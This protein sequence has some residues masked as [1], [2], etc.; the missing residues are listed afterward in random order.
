MTRHEFF[1]LFCRALLLVRSTLKYRRLTIANQINDGDSHAARVQG[2]L[3]ASTQVPHMTEDGVELLRR[4]YMQGVDVHK[5]IALSATI[6]ACESYKVPDCTEKR[7]E[8]AAFFCPLLFSTLGL[9]EMYELLCSLLIERSVVFVSENLNLLT[10]ASYIIW[11]N[12]NN[13]R[14]A[15]CSLIHPLK[16]QYILIPIVP[17]PLRELLDAP[18]PYIAGLNR[19]ALELRHIAEGAGSA[20]IVLLDSG[21]IVHPEEPVLPSLG[22]L[23]VAL[24]GAYKVFQRRGEAGLHYSA[25]EAETAAALEITARIESALQERVFAKLP[26][27]RSLVA[28][29]GQEVDLETVKSRVKEACDP[30]DKAFVERFAD[31]QMFANYVEDHYVHVAVPFI[32]E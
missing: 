19:P 15:C 26:S 7:K 22:G 27:F 4:I 20:S 18:L 9:N 28:A 31:T 21:E 17:N 12:N 16:W 25:T 11:Y 8:T 6:G 1:E 10:S 5:E 14:M 24:E 30:A 2:E 29:K 3:E 13:T 23:K 32:Q